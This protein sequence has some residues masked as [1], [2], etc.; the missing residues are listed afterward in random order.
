MS[1]VLQAF[2]E[3]LGMSIG[4]FI[5]VLVWCVAWKLIALWHAARKNHLTWFIVLAI[6]N[7]VG[8]LPILYLF[9]FKNLIVKKKEAPATKKKKNIS[10][11]KKVAKKR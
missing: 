8:I 4:L 6:F 10:K 11:K 9:I 1:E 3:Q 7:T 2:S 5:L